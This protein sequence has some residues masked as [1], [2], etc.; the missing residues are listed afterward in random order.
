MET[1]EVTATTFKRISPHSDYPNKWLISGVTGNVA[2][3]M[4]G[5]TFAGWDYSFTHYCEVGHTPNGHTLYMFTGD[6][7]PS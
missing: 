7:V 1:Y 2:D 6:R 5:F 3:L 4:S